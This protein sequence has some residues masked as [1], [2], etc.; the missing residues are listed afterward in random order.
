MR[1]RYRRSVLRTAALLACTCATAG[2][3]QEPAA[4]ACDPAQLTVQPERVSFAGGRVSLVP[5]PGVRVL[6]ALER[7]GRPAGERADVVLADSAGTSIALSL[8]EGGMPSRQ[9]I[10]GVTYFVEAAATSAG[11]FRWVRPGEQVN[12]GGARWW[13]LEFEL[14]GATGPQHVWQYITGFQGREL[15]VRFVTPVRGP[16]RRPTA[17]SVATLRLHDCAL[18]ADGESPLSLVR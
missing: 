16:G 1:S 11:D 12:L 10:Q 7:E 17:A 15:G 4:R 3:A 5:P 13:L 9:V 18:P 2:R 14:Q 8:G 6:T